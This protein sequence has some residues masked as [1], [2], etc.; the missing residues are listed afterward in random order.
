MTT[1]TIPEP[2]HGEAH[3]EG[4]GRVEFDYPA[5]DVTPRDPVAKAVVAVLVANG[6]ATVK[7]PS[8][9]TDKKAAPSTAEP[10]PEKE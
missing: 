6:Q 9:T 5:G 4:H 3:I 1:F 8:R 10:E 7:P 2:V